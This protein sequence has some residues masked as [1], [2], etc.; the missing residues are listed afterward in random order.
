MLKTNLT[1]MARVFIINSCGKEKVF[2][3]FKSIV[4]MQAEHLC[5]SAA[6]AATARVKALR[7]SRTPH[8]EKNGF[9]RERDRDRC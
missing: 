1:P 3:L 8:K 7:T 4:F 6:A 5:D 2:H 9:E